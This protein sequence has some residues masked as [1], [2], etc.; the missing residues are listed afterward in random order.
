MSTAQ[1]LFGNVPQNDTLGFYK[2][3]VPQYKKPVDFLNF[4]KD[5]VAVAT[6]RPKNSVRY[7]QKMPEELKERLIEWATAI[8]LVAGYFNDADKT[9]TWFQVPN[10][11]LGSISPRDMIRLGRF[12]KLY[13]FITTALD[14]NVR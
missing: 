12:K 10:P 14:E 3:G 8:N 11:E 13:K 7:D 4:R 2:N 1:V 6:N 5:D 9:M